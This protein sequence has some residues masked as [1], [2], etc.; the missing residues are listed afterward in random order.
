MGKLQNKQR[1]LWRPQNT[2]DYTLMQSTGCQQ[3]PTKKTS[4]VLRSAAPVRLR[5]RQQPAIYY[6]RMTL[7]NFLNII[8]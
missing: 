2:P 7:K 8:W 6:I 5:K 4:A 3:R 1:K